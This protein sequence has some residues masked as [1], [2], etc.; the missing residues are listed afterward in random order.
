MRRAA[1]IAGGVAVFVVPAATFQAS[2]QSK[3]SPAATAPA[4]ATAPGPVVPESVDQLL[5]Q[6]SDYIGSAE[7]F[8]FRADVTF[9]HV[10]PS[11]QKLQFSAT[12]EVALERPN[13]L[14]VE[15]SGDLGQRQFWYDGK[16]MTIYD[17]EAAFYGVDAAPPGIDTMLDKLIT[18]LDFTPPLTDFL[19]SD[20]Y[21]SVRGSI[22]YGFST[23]E[24]EINGRSCRG[25]AFVDKNIDWQIWIDTGPQRVPCK[26]LI[27]YKTHPAQPQFG[28]VFGDWDFS[29]RIAASTFAPDV[30]PGTQ[31]IPL[32]SV[33]AAV[34]SK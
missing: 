21:K 23:D 28:A 13:G 25:L 10:L 33:T 8:T 24:T 12:E 6:M 32:A 30:P 20:P 3:P 9:D 31:A 11:G 1:M 2:A 22:Q 19:Y 5:R 16:T 4:P 17:P 29:P 18:Q 7:H 27:T 15:W 26:L 34:G 14:Y